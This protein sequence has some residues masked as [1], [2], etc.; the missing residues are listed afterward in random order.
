[1]EEHEGEGLDLDWNEGEA[2]EACAHIPFG[3]LALSLL[4]PGREIPLIRQVLE[5]TKW[6][7]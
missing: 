6:V 3:R 7:F 5:M 2:P 4:S 1:M